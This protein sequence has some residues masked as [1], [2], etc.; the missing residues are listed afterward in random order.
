ME[1]GTLRERIP[2]MEDKLVFIDESG[3]DYTLGDKPG[4][5]THYVLA[6]I[7][8]NSGDGASVA[9][10]F[11]QVKGRHFAQAKEMKSQSIGDDHRK[12]RLVLL[13]L[14]YPTYA[15]YVLMVDKARLRGPGFKHHASFV[16]FLLD[17]LI[18]ELLRDSQNLIIRCDNIK[19]KEFM[20]DVA[21]YLRRKHPVTLFDSWDF[22]FLDSASDI[23]VQAADV[24]AGS[25]A[26][27]WEP[28]KQSPDNDEFMRIL[29]NPLEAGRFRIFPG[30]ANQG[31]RPIG[32]HDSTTHDM[33]IERRAVAEAERFVE[34]FAGTQD[35]SRQAQV[36][37]VYAFL[38]HNHLQRSDDWV[39]TET[40]RA[41]YREKFG[42][43]IE[44]QKLRGIIGVL[45]DTGLLIASRSAGGY[46]L[47]TSAADLHDFV[48][49]CNSKIGPMVA[50]IRK[51]RETIK[52][53]TDPPLDILND[54]EFK[55]LKKALDATPDWDAKRPPASLDVDTFN[56]EQWESALEAA[57]KV[58]V[59]Q[60]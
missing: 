49:N 23:C 1:T 60:N 44:L 43:D 25:L 51:V 9:N 40:L 3:D 59:T 27:C 5:S 13:D 19:S 11:H 26:R 38:G 34:E 29:A 48:D 18:T 56:E 8:I 46:K 30:T 53:T 7:V 57:R 24:I 50:R 47:P 17:R 54:P 15:L 22:A 42:Q 4:A 20:D 35:P 31:T 32:L 52:R 14:T 45:R 21:L 16:K 55:D 36:G 2:D 37:F 58:T 12:R 41:R 10:C 33:A 28:S 6:A 39:A